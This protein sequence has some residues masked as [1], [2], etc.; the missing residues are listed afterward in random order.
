MAGTHGEGFKVASLVMLREAYQVRF[1]AS[2]FYWNFRF[3]GADKDTLHCFFSTPKDSTIQ[4]QVAAYQK[5]AGKS[6]SRELKAN[7]WEDVSVKIG[8]VHDSQGTKIELTDF[9]DWLQVSLNLDRPTKIIETARGTLILDPGFGGRIYLKSLLLETNSVKEWRFGYNLFDGK[10]NRDRQRLTNPAEEASV[11][12]R[13]WE[14]AIQKEEEETLDD[15]VKML[16]E[17]TRWADVRLVKNHMSEATA[18]KVWQHLLKG[19]PERIRF[20]HDHKNGDEIGFACHHS[21]S[22]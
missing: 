3:V 15:Y 5:K 16:K 11:L 1:E 14:E 12:A 2:R 4:K 6:R 8:K 10:V 17:D 20:Y 7:L 22:T 19:D 9:K 13:I 21:I 18:Q